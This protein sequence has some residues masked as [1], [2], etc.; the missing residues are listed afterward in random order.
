MSAH[1]TCIRQL[2]YQSY[3]EI[4]EKQRKPDRK[5]SHAP[6]YVVIYVSNLLNRPLNVFN[7]KNAKCVG[8]LPNNAAI[9]HRNKKK[10]QG[11][12]LQIKSRHKI[13]N[14][15]RT[16]LQD[17]I[18]QMVRSICIR[19]GRIMPRHRFILKRDYFMH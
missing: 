11:E 13:M 8:R 9:F 12:V 17:C 14:V 19:A 2:T 18:W 4:T 1:R 3:R 16:L 15:Q 7:V 6:N 5:F 10:D